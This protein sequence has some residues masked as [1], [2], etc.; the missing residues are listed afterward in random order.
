MRHDGE[1]GRRIDIR[2]SALRVAF[3]E[4][5]EHIFYPLFFCTQEG[6][7]LVGPESAGMADY[8]TELGFGLTQD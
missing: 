4:V 6:L 2:R 3:L 8:K 7:L 1:R 5:G